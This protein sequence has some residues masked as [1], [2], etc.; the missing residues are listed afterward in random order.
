MGIFLT[1]SLIYEY[2]S[3]INDVIKNCGFD[4]T[5][6]KISYIKITNATGYWANIGKDCNDNTRYGIHVSRIFEKIPNEKDAILRL[7]SCLIHEIIHTIPGCE[8]THKGKF[9]KI[10]NE[11]IAY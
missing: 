9:A 6:Q 11:I 4:F 5:P 10:C 1:E 3:C 8:N 2:I 7:K